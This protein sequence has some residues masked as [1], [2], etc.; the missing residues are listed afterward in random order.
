MERS[1]EYL[2]TAFAIGARIARDAH[3]ADGRCT[4]IGAMMEPG[5]HGWAV[6]Q[7][8]FGPDLYS[9]TAGVALF[10]GRL[11]AATGEAVF[12]KTA[13]GALRHALTKDE[14]FPAA[15][16][17]SF[18]SGAAGVA[19]AAIECG[20]CGVGEALVDQGVSRLLGLAR[21]EPEEPEDLDVVSGVAASIVAWL[22]IHSR[23][24]VPDLLEAAVRAGD[25]IVRR[26]ARDE[27]G[28]SWALA[29]MPTKHNLT[30]LGH[31]ASGYA[32]ALLELFAATRDERYRDTAL[33]AFRYE[34]RWFDAE[35][36]NWPDFRESGEAPVGEEG[37]G[38]ALAWCHGAP[39][40]GLTRVRAW[41]LTGNDVLRGEGEAALRTTVTAWEQM[42]AAGAT[43][44]SLCHGAAGNADLALLAARVFG[45]PAAARVAAAIADAGIE[46]FE[47]PRLVWP[48]GVTGGGET[49]SLMLGAAGTGYF[50]LRLVDPS[51][52]SV[53]LL[54]P[55]GA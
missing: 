54:D 26:A 15:M 37:P 55:G 43:N 34:R 42:D 35:H 8:G 16:R 6:A 2:E 44:Y 29:S 5:E 46:R 36:G 24:G 45:D 25:D 3:W 12:R 19:W 14:R 23:F 13:A 30:G 32:W 38:F 27:T 50:L 52:P 33:D 4:W 28:V 47:R 17:R 7:R 40:I 48:G 20:E 1:A 53:L 39:G 31:G 22:H 18:F 41:Q 21:A 49:A 11:H 51:V 9:G 10:L